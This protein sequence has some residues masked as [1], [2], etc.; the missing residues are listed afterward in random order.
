MQEVG[1][2]LDRRNLGV[3][4]ETTI[5]RRDTAIWKDGCSLNDSQGGPAVRERREMREVEIRQVA[6]ISGI[7]AHGCNLKGTCYFLQFR[8]RE[9]H[10]QMRFW[11]VTSR[12]LRGV[13]SV[14]GLA[15]R[16]LPAGVF[17]AGVKYG[18]LGAAGFFGDIVGGKRIA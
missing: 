6:V 1:Q 18:V 15:D 17:W 4:P 9:L 12:I 14:G 7:R 3:G 16:A 5:F 13:K 8:L 10:T 2:A 11:K